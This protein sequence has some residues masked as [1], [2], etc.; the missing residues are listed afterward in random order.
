M[1]KRAELS[2]LSLAGQAYINLFSENKSLQQEVGAARK[3][4]RKDGVTT[5]KFFVKILA[6]K[7]IAEA[8]P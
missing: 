3:K 7:S 4:Y 6:C 1:E 8:H 2:H 5:G